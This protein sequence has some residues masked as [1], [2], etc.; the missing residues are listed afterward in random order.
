MS[1]RK[2]T[3]TAKIYSDDFEKGVVLSY[4]HAEQLVESAEILR[5]QGKHS[6]AIFLALHAMEELGKSAMLLDEIGQKRPWITDGRWE[7]KYRDHAH[8]LRRAHLAIQKNVYSVTEWEVAITLGG[9]GS[10]KVVSEGDQ[11]KRYA[12]YDVET[13]FGRLYVDHGAVGGQRQWTSPLAPTGFGTDANV[14]ID[15]AKAGMRA[16]QLEAEKHGITLG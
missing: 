10:K 11:M 12:K 16:I 2:V 4:E 8:K 14:E 7:D 5:D 6:P 1:K 3:P 15:L 9:S 13:K